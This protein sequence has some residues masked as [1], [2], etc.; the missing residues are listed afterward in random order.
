VPW[1]TGDPLRATRHAGGLDEL[2]PQE[3]PEPIMSRKLILAATILAAGFIVG[4]FAPEARRLVWADPL[5]CVDGDVNA[6]GALDIADPVHLLR[7]LFLGGEPPT[8]C[9]PVPEPVSMVVIVRHAEKLE[10]AD[11]GL[12]PEGQARAQE[13]ARVLGPT[14]VKYIVASELLRT[15]ETVQPLATAKGLVMEK[16]KEPADVVKYMEG[17]PAGSIAVVAHHSYTIPSILESLG[18]EGW[19]DIDVDGM[20]YD[21]FIVALRAAGRKTQLLHLK[22]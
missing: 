15:Q 9:A 17:L 14:E 13:L 5:S 12:T 6:D 19:R 4:R 7:F 8:S 18:V 2:E 20:N 10:G 16:I 1:R 21:N 3:L 22:Y 11:P